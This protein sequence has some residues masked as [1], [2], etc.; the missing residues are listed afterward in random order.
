MAKKQK[1]LS[2]QKRAERVLVSQGRAAGMRGSLPQEVQESLAELCDVSGALAPGT[3]EA[4]AKILNDYW[5][6]Q[7]AVV[8]EP[9]EVTPEE[10]DGP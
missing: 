4:A 5:D 8:D 9:A 2:M 3:R 7:K 6:S 10:P 1:Q